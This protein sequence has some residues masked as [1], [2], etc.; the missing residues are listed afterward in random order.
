[1]II[2][3]QKTLKIFIYCKVTVLNSFFGVLQSPR[4]MLLTTRAEN[5]TQILNSPAVSQNYGIIPFRRQGG[6]GKPTDSNDMLFVNI[7]YSRSVMLKYTVFL[8]RK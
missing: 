2:L 3:N 8:L 1:M 4:G 5:M 7:V 6:P